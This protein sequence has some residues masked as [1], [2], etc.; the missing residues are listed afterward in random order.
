MDTCITLR[1]LF[2]ILHLYSYVFIKIDHYMWNYVFYIAYLW[3]QEEN[4]DNGVES[5]IRGKL[6]PNIIDLSW[7]PF[8]R[9]FKKL[10][11]VI[12]Y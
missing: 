11:F 3:N 9:S 1:F 12:N 5:Y 7:F 8:G 2:Q 10:S 4:D 6:K